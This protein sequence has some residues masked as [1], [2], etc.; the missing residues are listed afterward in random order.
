MPKYMNNFVVCAIQELTNRIEIGQVIKYKGIEI[1]EG[2][3]FNKIVFFHEDFPLANI[4]PI[5]L[6]VGV[7]RK[8]EVEVN[9]N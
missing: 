4:E 7:N 3:E 6:E 2:Y 5:K 8:L 9:R 1:R